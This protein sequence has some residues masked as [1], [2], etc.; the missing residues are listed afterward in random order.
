VIWQVRLLDLAGIP[1]PVD[2][3]TNLSAALDAIAPSTGLMAAQAQPPSGS[4]D[5]CR[6]TPAGGYVGLENQLYRVHVHDLDAGRPV[7]LWSREN[8]SVV[9]TWVASL[10]ADTLQVASIGKDAVL[11]F[12]PG[13]WVEL[14]DDSRVLDARPGTL[15]RL[16]N[17]REDKLTL[18]VTTAT[19]STAITDFPRNP[20]VRRW[21][22]PGT[23]AV[24]DDDW[25]DLEDGVQV[26]FPAG[27]TFRRHDY[28]LI[29]AR[30]VLADIDWPHDSGGEPLAVPAS[31][32]RHDTGRLAIV[33][34]SAS[35]LDVADCRDLFPSLTSSAPTTSRSAT[36]SAT[37]PASRRSR[38]PST[39]SAVPT[40]CAATTDSCTATASSAASPSTAA[41]G[42]TTT[43][44]RHHH[45]RS[46]H[47]VQGEQRGRRTSALR[48]GGSRLRH[49]RR[50]QR[51]RRARADRGRRP[52]GDRGAR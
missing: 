8:A 3:D 22:S 19:G 17:A 42:R 44:R 45:R 4:A 7:L 25:I 35:G 21:D 16:L 51:P 13:D 29:P 26:R 31:G 39:R 33:T 14:Y 32:I 12:Q 1:E 50:R 10:A 5:E 24:P 48:H 38:T 41:P 11:G 49:R 52:E 43:D 47:A 37:S 20:Q 46:P 28:W 30:S 23:V 36:T 27:G 6:P 40:T 9:T 34:R 15:V 2:C 18:D